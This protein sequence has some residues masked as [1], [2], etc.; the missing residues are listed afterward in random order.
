MKAQLPSI[1]SY[2]QYSSD[3]YGA[4]TLRVDIGPLTVWFSYKTPV[5]FQV[6]G[7]P[8]VVRKNDWAATTGKH[9]NWIDGGKDNPQAKKRRVDSET[10]D[11][12]WVQHVEPLFKEDAPAQAP[13]IFDDLTPLLEN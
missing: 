5:A 1:S 12:L 3:N 7:K 9:L 10:F 4:H 11:N 8:R 2:G 13:G 6:D